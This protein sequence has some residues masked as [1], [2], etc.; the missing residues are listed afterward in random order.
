M[1][2]KPRRIKSQLCIDKI[3]KLGK[4]EKCT[5]ENSLQVH[6]IKSKGARGGDVESN[7]VCLCYTCH[8]MVHDGNISRDELKRIVRR[9]KL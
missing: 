4:C 8:R 6:H 3:R 2:P 9:R 1:F 5:A 7:L